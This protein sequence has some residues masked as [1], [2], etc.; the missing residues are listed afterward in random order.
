MGPVK[1]NDVELRGSILPFPGQKVTERRLAGHPGDQR[2]KRKTF[3]VE[4]ST[5]E[6]RTRYA[7]NS[8]RPG[9]PKKI[10]YVG[11]S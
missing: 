7:G 6:K 10:A 1:L 4:R 3:S 8:R 11:V 9:A 2:E 5:R